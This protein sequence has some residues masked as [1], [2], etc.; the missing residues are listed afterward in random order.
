VNGLEKEYGERIRFVR[1]NILLA[2]SR[3]MMDQYAFSAAPEFF[4]LDRQ[5]KTIGFWDE[6]SA[7]NDMKQV[8]EEA[9]SQSP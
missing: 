6:L 4:L 9:L 2:E 1:V 5:G 8:F 3:P 7:D